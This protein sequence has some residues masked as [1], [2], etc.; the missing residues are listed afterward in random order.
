MKLEKGDHICGF[1]ISSALRTGITT[2]TPRGRELCISPKRYGGN[3]AAKGQVLLKRGQLPP[4]ELP[5]IRL[6]TCFATDD[7][8]Q[9]LTQDE[10]PAVSESS[11]ESTADLTV[12]VPESPQAPS[13]EET[14]EESSE[15]TSEDTTP[16]RLTSAELRAHHPATAT[17]G[18]RPAIRTAGPARDISDAPE[19]VATTSANET[20]ADSDDSSDELTDLPLFKAFPPESE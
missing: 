11:T 8:G 10:P 18:K 5:L 7:A 15:E 16:T 3:R 20:E 13:T 4:W 2:Q 14:R 19:S 9:T 1:E 6:D 17:E 12:S